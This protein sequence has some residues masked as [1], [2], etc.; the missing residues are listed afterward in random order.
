M[1][2]HLAA[3]IAIG[4]AGSACAT[5]GNTPLAELPTSPLPT[6]ALA[7]QSVTV[8]PLTMVLAEVELGWDA[9]LTP[10]D[11]ALRRADSI[12]AMAVTSR[13]PEVMWVLPEALRR[14]SSRAPGMLTDPDRMATS[15]LRRRME[16]LPDPLRSQMRMLTGAAG[17]RWALVPASLFF[18]VDSTAVGRG[19]AEL[20]VALTD[21]RAGTV[22]WQTVAKG[23]GEDPWSA[24]ADALRTMVPVF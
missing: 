12:F 24:L 23:V 22:S 2:R 3:A 20:T 17:D 10:R 11:S 13:A 8:Y 16:R 6:T 4:I 18:F 1:A 21:V 14:A 5:A 9:S 7:G 19:R 15:I